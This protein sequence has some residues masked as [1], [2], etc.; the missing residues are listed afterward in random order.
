MLAAIRMPTAPVA[1]A[2]SSVLVAWA[3]LAVVPMRH[4]PVAFTLMWVV[5]AVAMM[6]PTILR[7]MR[8]IAGDSLA[9]STRFLLGYLTIWAVMALP[10]LALM[11][12]PWTLT[13]VALAWMLVG[14]YQVSPWTYRSLRACRHLQPRDD[15]WRSGLR[16]GRACVV[17]CGPLMIAAMVTAMLLPPVLAFAFML[18]AT[19]FMVWEKGP[20][21]RQAAMHA[22]AL[23]FVVIG[24]LLWLAGPSGAHIHI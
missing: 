6:V 13:G 11:Q 16:Q 7:P 5:M 18:A 21:I 20:R 10:A 12:L 9:R 22:S 14:G 8:R 4:D 1:L 24:V 17:A 3:A 19:I 2:M 15:A 23:L